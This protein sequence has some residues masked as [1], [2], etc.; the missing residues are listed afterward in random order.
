M[1]GFKVSKKC[2]YVQK[3]SFCKNQYRYIIKRKNSLLIS[4][5]LN[6]RKN[7]LHTVIT[8]VKNSIFTSL[9]LYADNFFRVILIFPFNRVP[10]KATV[11]H[12]YSVR[13][14]EKQLFQQNK[15]DFAYAS[16]THLHS[17]PPLFG[18]SVP[19]SHKY[20]LQG[21][22]YILLGGLKEAITAQGVGQAARAGDGHGRRRGEGGDCRLP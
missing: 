18:C 7:F 5:P 17:M 16:T 9:L 11:G 12:E 3:V 2:E 22:P 21:C 15:D 6:N 14:V 10:R 1:F 4:K 13:P 19:E 20:E 8:K